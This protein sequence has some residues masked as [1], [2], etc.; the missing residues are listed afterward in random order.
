MI[1]VR[2]ALT[3]KPRRGFTLIELLVVIAII[4]VLISLIAPAVQSARKAAFNLQCLNNLH[5]FGIAMTNFATA[6]GSRLPELE[7]SS[8]AETGTTP[9]ADSTDV[10]GNP[11]YGWPR[12][13]LSALDRADLH[14]ALEADSQN[15]VWYISTEEVANLGATPTGW[16]SV[17][18]APTLNQ[19]VP[20]FT[21]PVDQN[22]HKIPMGLSYGVNMGFM[23]STAYAGDEPYV[24]GSIHHVFNVKPITGTAGTNAANRAAIRGS[25]VFWRNGGVFA[26][27]MTPVTLDDISGGDG[28]GQTILMGEN[29][30]SG[31]W[32]SRDADYIGIGVPVTVDSNGVPT[33]AVPAGGIGGT[34]IATS[35]AGVQAG[36]YTVNTNSTVV[37]EMS[38]GINGAARGTRPRASSNHAG[39]CNF[40]FGDGSGK[41][42]SVNMNQGVYAQLFSWDGQRR[43]QGVV[44]ASDFN[45]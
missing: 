38:R 23:A 2:S 36:G 37:G 10:T 32:L 7:S 13:L 29:I 4:A 43:G 24:A 26:P 6:N 17:N 3:P 11:G 16:T 34:T 27:E 39:T 33:P 8:L 44:N 18:A 20:V 45:R 30:Q 31:N 5:Q 40:L 15:G 41:A 12:I 35:L 9:G 42:L 1:R 14:R 21:C 25:G 19:W 28:L 22:N